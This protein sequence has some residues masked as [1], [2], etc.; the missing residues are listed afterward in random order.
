MQ[1]SINPDEQTYLLDISRRAMACQFQFLLNAGEQHSAAETAVQALDLV[2]ELEEQ[3]SI[4]RSESQI[5]RVNR[6]AAEK[7]QSVSPDVYQLLTLAKQIWRETNGAFDIT[8]TPLS[9]VW[10]FHTRQSNLPLAADITSAQQTVGCQ[11]LQ[12]K[13]NAISFDHPQLAINLG[14]I[15]KG[16]ALD[17]CHQHFAGQQIESYL[18]HA[19]HSSILAHGNRK[20]ATTKNRGWQIA[21]R[22]PLIPQRQLANFWLRDR[23]IGTSGDANQFF[24]HQGKRYGHVIDPR[25]GWPVQHTLSATV[26]THSAASADALATAFF[27]I[28]PE[29]ATRYCQQHPDTSF[30]IATPSERNRIIE[31][32]IFGVKKE[33][34]EI[35][36]KNVELVEY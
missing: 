11:F 10:G 26:I 16:Y 36:A 4:F 30:I 31:L 19:G 33:D 23:A 14:G 34:L 25:S 13:N 5:T 22:H 1:N 32:H 2:E 28:G 15:G 7:P 3:L 18:L 12:L 6:L 17:R 29:H 9:K 35:T 8:S 27:V 21:L 24:Y 20:K